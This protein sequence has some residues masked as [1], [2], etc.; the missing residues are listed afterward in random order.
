MRVRSL[1][2]SHL[3]AMTGWKPP[4]GVPGAS[5]CCSPL[6]ERHE[7]QRGVHRIAW[8]GRSLVPQ[9]TREA[10]RVCAELAEPSGARR[11]RSA[12]RPRLQMWKELETALSPLG[13]ALR[14]DIITDWDFYWLGTPNKSHQPPP[15]SLLQSALASLQT[16]KH[17]SHTHTSVARPVSPFFLVDWGFTTLWGALH[18]LFSRLPMLNIL[19][20]EEIHHSLSPQNPLMPSDLPFRWTQNMKM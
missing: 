12:S 15:P 17:C 13:A 14:G 10:A 6:C 1:V 11:G 20:R 4:R 16:H 9:E 3:P 18:I 5:S 8:G 2:T 7:P 19:C